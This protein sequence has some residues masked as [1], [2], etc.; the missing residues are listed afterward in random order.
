MCLC[1]RNKDEDEGVPC[2]SDFE[3]KV[4]DAKVRGLKGNIMPGTELRAGF[5]KNDRNCCVGWLNYDF[6]QRSENPTCSK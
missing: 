6:F 3:K 4:W 5:E 2:E 1:S